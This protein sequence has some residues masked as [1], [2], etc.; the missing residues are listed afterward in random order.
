M[1]GLRTGKAP[2]PPETGN[3]IILGSDGKFWMQ[4]VVYDPDPD[5]GY[6]TRGNMSITLIASETL[7]VLDLGLPDESGGM[8]GAQSVVVI[9]QYNMIVEYDLN[10][11]ADQAKL[12]YEQKTIMDDSVEDVD[13]DIVLKF[14]KF[15]LEEG[16]NDIIVD[17]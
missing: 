12:P 3:D 10:G 16:G 1:F 6:G 14:N 9:T 17:G 13:G 11:Y 7:G 4:Y 8:V 15:L 5:A 2:E